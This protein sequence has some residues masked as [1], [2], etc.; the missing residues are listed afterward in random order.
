[1][2]GPQ[3]APVT[4]PQAVALEE[5]CAA[6]NGEGGLERDAD[7]FSCEVCHGFGTLPTDLGRAILGLIGKYVKNIELVTEDEPEW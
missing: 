3:I 1:M 5:K 6:C 4:L 7:W 2:I